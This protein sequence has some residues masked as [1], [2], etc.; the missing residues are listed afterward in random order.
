MRFFVFF[1]ICTAARGVRQRRP[2]YRAIFH[3]EGRQFGRDGRLVLQQ[4]QY[5]KRVHS[6]A[7]RSEYA[8]KKGDRE[9]KRIGHSGVYILG[10][11]SAFR[12][13]FSIY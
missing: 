1:L 9:Q 3:G 4:I 6:L 13:V 2:G 11:L 12:K 5:R 8:P 7:D 10:D